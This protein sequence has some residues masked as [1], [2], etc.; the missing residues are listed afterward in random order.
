[1]L[2]DFDAILSA[3]LS[4]SADERAM[5]AEHLLASLD[6]PNQKEIDAAW[7]KEAERRMREIDEGK[8]RSDRRRVGDGRDCERDSGGSNDFHHERLFY[9]WNQC[10]CRMCTTTLLNLG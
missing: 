6:S 10:L 7:A 1:M 2:A 5:L 4:L 9:G 8:G 3:A